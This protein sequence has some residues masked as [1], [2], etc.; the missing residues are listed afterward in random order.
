MSNQYLD[1]VDATSGSHQASK[2][3]LP[4]VSDK[5]TTI[6][7]VPF[8]IHVTVPNAST[9]ILRYAP[10][11]LTVVDAWAIAKANG[12]AG[13]L[14]QVFNG[15]T[16][17]TDAIDLSGADQAIVRATTIDDAAQAFSEGDAITVDPTSAT[18]CSCELYIV[19]LP[20]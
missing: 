17:V 14:V 18:D 11:D 6:P 3:D 5:A 1:C 7:A 8:V 9:N 10:C 12:A 4:V 15:A 20:A 16:P 2:L 19:C 13:D